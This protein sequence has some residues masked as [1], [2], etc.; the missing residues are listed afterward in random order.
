VPTSSCVWPL[1]SGRTAWAS[2][3]FSK[4]DLGMVMKDER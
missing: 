3:T 2:Q 4:S 1:D